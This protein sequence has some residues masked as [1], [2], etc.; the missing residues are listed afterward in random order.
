VSVRIAGLGWV[1]PLGAG[2]DENWTRLLRGDVVEIKAIANP[3]TGREHVYAPVPPKTVEAL[4][5]NPRLRRSSAISYF[6]VAAG[7]AAL[8]DA[9]VTVTP[10]AAA[11][12]ALVFAISS[13]GVIYT[14]KFYEQIVKQGA[15]AASPLLFPE[16][17]YNAPASH[18]AAQLGIDG[19]SY[20]LVGDGSIGLS[21]LKFAEQLLATSDLDRVVVV[22]SEEIDWILCEAYGDW[23]LTRRG[24][25]SRGAL[26]AE[27]AAAL[28]L[29][30]GG[31]IGLALH[32]GVAVFR[33][34]DAAAALKKAVGELLAGAVPDAVIGCANGTF[35]DRAE[36]AVLSELCPRSRAYFLKQALGEALGAGALMQT[37]AA[38]LALKK[39]QLPGVPDRSDGLETA[40]VTA[41]G[42][43]QQASAA[44]L[45]RAP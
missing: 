1:T 14:R 18:L 40:L 30:R 42:F 28:V 15:N 10:E 31:S 6:A 43:N 7:L 13:G 39:G 25:Q 27:G 19:A 35:I 29:A 24:L 34:S 45:Q 20:T 41:L 17:V 5:R 38:A 11:R 3:E 2:L 16:T 36:R 8:E 33:R 37:V 44:L 32:Q 22:G 9:G 23:R 21:A 4:G 26:L 12:T